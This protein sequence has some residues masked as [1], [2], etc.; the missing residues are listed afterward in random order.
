MV[1]DEEKLRKSE[2]QSM[3]KSRVGNRYFRVDP[4]YDKAVYENTWQNWLKII[5]AFIVFYIVLGLFFWAVFSHGIRD[6]HSA[7]WIYIALIIVCWILM[8]I[9]I[10]LGHKSTKKL[11]KADRIMLDVNEEKKR[12]R[13]EEEKK[14]KREEAKKEMKKL[15]MQEL[16][17]EE[18]DAPA[19]KNKKGGKG[20]KV[21]DTSESAAEES[22]DPEDES[23]PVSDEED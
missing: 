11:H 7:T 4:G 16:A 14:Q 13:E 3:R 17:S 10:Y 15:E 12:R 5:G 8:G 6:I 1:Q 9:L 22:R 20:K 19:T 23:T 21:S 18:S 2:D